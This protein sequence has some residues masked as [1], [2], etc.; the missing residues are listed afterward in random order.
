MEIPNAEEVVKHLQGLGDLNYVE[1]V[2]L[3][4][5]ITDV[6]NS[7]VSNPSREWDGW[8]WMDQCVVTKEYITIPWEIEHHSRYFECP[9]L[10]EWLETK[11]YS[12]VF[13]YYEKRY[14]GYIIHLRLYF[15]EPSSE[16]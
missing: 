6:L 13:S 12:P 3:Q 1:F 14:V 9:K 10:V 7:I 15:S 4:S 16:D 11:G 2:K 8:D 5:R